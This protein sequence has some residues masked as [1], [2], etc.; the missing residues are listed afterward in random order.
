M[1]AAATNDTAGFPCRLC[2]R[3][4]RH[5]LVDLGMSPLC[6]AFLRAEELNE[7]EPYYPLRVWLCESCLLAQVEPYVAPAE[8]FRDYAYF[9]SY[10]T[11]WVDHA[12]TYADRMTRTLELGASSFV[13]ELASNDGYLLQH[14]V[15]LNVPALGIDPAA[16]VADAARRRGVETLTEFFDPD[17]ARRVVAE[18]GNADLVVANNV[19]AHVPALNDFVTGIRLLLAPTG[20]ATLEVPH[21]VR[22]VEGLQ[23]DTIYHEH[24]SYFSFHTLVTLFE[25]NGLQVFDVEELASHGG[26]LR[27]FVRHPRG[28]PTREVEDLLQRE[29][30]GGYDRVAGYDGF[31]ARVAEARWRLLEVL[32]EHRRSGK[33]VAAYGAPGKGNT[34]LNYCGIR[35]DLI[36]Y[37][38]DRNPHKQGKFLPGTHIPIHAPDRIAETRPDEILILPWNLKREIAAQLEYVRDWGG[39]LLVPIPQPEFVT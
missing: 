15:P 9:S 3:A 4:L 26:S 12:R 37:T 6:E 22:L 14:F 1:N 32:I 27:V 8:I 23:F 35:G 7:M 11:S 17:V 33:R 34:L 5:T 16:N 29:R 20:V 13:V 18:R 25:R 24:Y 39:R 21:L 28:E 19:L 2:G 36:E 38:V 30:A 10:S 31:A